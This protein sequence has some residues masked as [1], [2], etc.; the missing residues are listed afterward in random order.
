MDIRTFAELTTPDER[1]L[2]FTPLGLATGGML[3]PENA[4]EFQQRSIS[5]A[6][7][8]PA[9]PEGTRSSFERL[10]TLH[11]YG[12]LCYDLFTVV[13]DLTW[14]V[15]E[16]ALRERFIEFYGRVIPLGSKT[17]AESM[18]SASDFEAVSQGYRLRV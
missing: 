18:L 11:A 9:V 14:V 7:L 5:T 13:E 17:A 1:S 16:Q 12:V 3:S 2:R 4:A 6:D 10:R 15:L 8:V